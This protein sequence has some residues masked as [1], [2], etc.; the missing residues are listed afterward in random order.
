MGAARHSITARRRSASARLSRPLVTPD[1]ASADR[2][3]RSHLEC[4]ATARSIGRV[5]AVA[6]SEW[7]GSRRLKVVETISKKMSIPL[8]VGL[9][10]VVWGLV[11]VVAWAIHPVEGVGRSVPVENPSP[12]QQASIDLVL[13]DP[14]VAQTDQTVRFQCDSSPLQAA[15]GDRGA[16][17][18]PVLDL[19]FEY[20]EPPCSRA[21]DA[22]RAAMWANALAIAAVVIASIVIHVRLRNRPMTEVVAADAISAGTYAD[23]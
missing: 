8:W 18:A 9:A 22:A 6:A 16:S 12:T 23:S 11:L 13:G 5:V 10:G 19:G 3:R 14:D 2:R 20:D 15:A 1:L 17:R 21:Y 4:L 7:C